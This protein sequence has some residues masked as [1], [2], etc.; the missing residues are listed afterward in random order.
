MD[1]KWC[2]VMFM[3]AVSQMPKYKE[4]IEDR[5]PLR[6]SRRSGAAAIQLDGESCPLSS[7]LRSNG[8]ASET[9]LEATTHKRLRS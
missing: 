8:P 9:V 6:K 3:G 4:I 2:R 5:L 7:A 1:T